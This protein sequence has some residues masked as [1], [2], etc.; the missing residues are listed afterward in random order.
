MELR[1][2]ILAWLEGD[3]DYRVRSK[4]PDFYLREAIEELDRVNR[5]RELLCDMLSA[6]HKMLM[7]AGVGCS[8]RDYI[9]KMGEEDG[10]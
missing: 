5:D 8:S 3:A 1:D 4:S 10:T 2:E 7:S 6:A 9:E